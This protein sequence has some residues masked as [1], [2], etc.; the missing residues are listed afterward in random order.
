[1]IGYLWRTLPLIAKASLGRDGR[2]V[3]RIDRRVHLREIDP[4]LHMNQAV[5]A[6]VTELGRADWLI[7]SRAW[8]QW[9]SE[10]TKPVV[11]EQI[12]VYR[13][14]LRLGTRYTIDTRCIAID[15]RLLHLRSL[16]LVGDRVHTQNDA[17]LIF[18][19]GDGVLDAA[20]VEALCE[21][22]ISEPLLVQDWRIVGPGQSEG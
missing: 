1:M 15:G 8:S 4:N 3:S 5:Y 2:L 14:E 13:R 10:E 12:L 22:F 20:S 9:R 7:R 17:K 11:A 16:V 6:Q 18:I 19:G 21:K